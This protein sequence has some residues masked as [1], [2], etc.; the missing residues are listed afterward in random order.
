V[1]QR[2]GQQDRDHGGGLATAPKQS[3]Y[4]WRTLAVTK[5]HEP[6]AS[7]L[8][9]SQ[10]AEHAFIDVHDEERLFEQRTA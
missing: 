8:R 9:R 3:S 6:C 5:A 4:A 10:S 1:R 2:T 7:A